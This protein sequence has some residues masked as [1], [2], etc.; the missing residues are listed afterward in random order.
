MQPARDSFETVLRL[1]PGMTD[2]R[3]M[4]AL[5]L[6]DQ[7]QDIAAIQLLTGITEKYPDHADAHLALGIL[8][9]KDKS[10]AALARKEFTTYLKLEPDSPKAKDI[11]NWIKYQ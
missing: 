1:S 5:V 2:A 6:T 4:L 9:K 7:G 3:Y 10:K 11:R 8:Y